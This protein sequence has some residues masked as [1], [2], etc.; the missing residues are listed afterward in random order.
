MASQLREGRKEGC[1]HRVSVPFVC[2]FECGRVVGGVSG[3]WLKEVHS[4]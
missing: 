4:D 1:C 3:L 2:P